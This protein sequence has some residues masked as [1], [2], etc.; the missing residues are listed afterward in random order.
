MRYSLLS[1]LRCPE[2]ADGLACF[3]SREAA[4]ETSLFVAETAARA[5]ALGQRFA[6]SPVF[7]RRTPIAAR[8]DA[9]AG[10]ADPTRNR[11]AAVESGVLICGGC[12]RWFPILASLPELLPDHLRDAAR[13]A[14][15]LDALAVDL[16]SDV[17][18][19]L[20]PP[21]PAAT[22]EDAG[23]HYKR[24]EIEIGS[25]VDDPVA[26][27]G[28]GYSAPFN[29]GNTEFTLYLL[30]LFANVAHML[31]VVEG[32]Q[33]AVVIDS[34]CGYAWTS[35]WLAKSGFETIGVDIC[36]AYLEIAISRIGEAHPH[37]IV[38]DI[39]HLPLADACA[40]AILAYESFHHIP[41]RRRAMAGYARVLK[42]R[43]TVVLAEPGAAHE[44]ADVS[45]ETM[46]R[47]GI[48]EKGM[49]LADVESYVDGAP[50]APPEQQ[51]VLHA[52]ATELERGIDLRSAWS[53]SLLPGNVFRLRKVAARAGD[54]GVPPAGADAGM[55]RGAADAAAAARIPADGA[56]AGA[57]RSVA[58][59][60]NPAARRLSAE[61]H[62]VTLDLHAARAAAVIAQRRVADMERSVF[63]KARRAW[64]RLAALFGSD[65]GDTSP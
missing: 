63:W 56:T 4:T 21:A 35:E 41:D 28:P 57:R 59:E 33:S 3:V 46:A 9:L 7:T 6:P 14:A 13:D 37:L 25:R 32:S 16:P 27:F 29:P 5:P 54:A 49:E 8:L 38:A 43:G 11:T 34:G 60:L 48:L 30:G 40:D 50:F 2:C 64:V 51:Y 45:I 61:L 36:R 42:D 44:T 18:S 12:A 39:E 26:F 52:S 24:A 10:P 65:R 55:S 23:A 62:A 15:L 53:H 1:Y 20:R 58:G 22:R 31:N 19:L 17:R 47:Y